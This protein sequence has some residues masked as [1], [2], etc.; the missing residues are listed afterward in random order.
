M[1]YGLGAVRIRATS[2][3]KHAKGPA[4]ISIGLQSFTRAFLSQ[5]SPHILQKAIHLINYEFSNS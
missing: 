4:V 5:Y 3:A 2:L 1:L